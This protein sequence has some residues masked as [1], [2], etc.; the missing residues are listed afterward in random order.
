L[1][2]A[3]R[4]QTADRCDKQFCGSRSAL[5]RTIYPRPATLTPPD[6]FVLSALIYICLARD[7]RQYG[8]KQQSKAKDDN[9]QRRYKDGR[10]DRSAK[11]PVR[12]WRRQTLMSE[13]IHE[14]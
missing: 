7:K 10:H 9:V 2:L 1:P 13:N 14:T 6:L 5:P 8:C 3:R 4:P 11:F 12:V